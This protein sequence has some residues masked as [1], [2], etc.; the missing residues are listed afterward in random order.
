MRM[1]KLRECMKRDMEIRGFSPNT[2]QAYLHQVKALTRYFGRAP[3]ALALE[4]IH[5]Y[6]LHLTRVRKVS[7]S[8]LTQVVAAL[9]FFYGVT[10]SKGWDIEQIP[11]PKTGRRLPVVLNQAE[12]LRLFD[13]LKNLKHLAILMTLYAAGLRVSEVVRLRISDIDSQRMMLF[14]H[15]GKG[16]KDRYVPQSL[17]LLGV[18]R[19]YWK[20]ERPRHWLFPGQ[21]ER[22]PLTRASVH[23]FFK[24]AVRKTGII[25][26]ITVHGIRHSYATHL[27]ESGVDLRKIQ[28]L[29]G[30]RSLRS[31]Q[32]YTHVAQNDL[33]GTPSP[34]DLLL[35]DSIEP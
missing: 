7:S 34:L 8:S 20:L 30:H 29:L 14:I 31:T 5:T 35:P 16:R 25:K 17:R 15:E 27:L 4:D 2:Q 21:D 32:I 26:P 28:L 13:S 18:L 23:K 19:E 9:R 33:D 24:K 11:Y 10:C 22:R 1:G 6:Q 12:L 3:D